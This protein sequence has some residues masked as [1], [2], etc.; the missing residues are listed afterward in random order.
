[1]PMWECIWAFVDED[2]AHVQTADRTTEP[3][4][5]GRRARHRAAAIL[6]SGGQA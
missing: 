4:F 3:G 1:M 6:A 2:G 5:A